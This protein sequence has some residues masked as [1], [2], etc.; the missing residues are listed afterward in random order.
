MILLARGEEDLESAYIVPDKHIG[1]VRS[2]RGSIPHPQEE[3]NRIQRQQVCYHITNAHQ[4][5]REVN[6]WITR[7]LH[8]K[9]STRVRFHLTKYPSKKIKLVCLA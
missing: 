6:S 2:K 9:M 4:R 8:P 1:G 3:M 7:L 5:Y